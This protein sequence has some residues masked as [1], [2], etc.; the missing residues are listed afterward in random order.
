MTGVM[1]C[2]QVGMTSEMSPM[3][4]WDGGVF[5]LNVLYTVVVVE[6]PMAAL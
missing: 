2:D 5:I 1:H 4:R 3:G 6:Y